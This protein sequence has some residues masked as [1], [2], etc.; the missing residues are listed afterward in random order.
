[1]GNME[2][3]LDWRGD[4]TFDVDP[5]NIVDAVILCQLIYTDFEGFV[6]PMG[7]GESVSIEEVCERYFNAYTDEEIISRK[8]YTR[9]SPFLMRRMVKSKRYAGLRLSNYVDEVDLDSDIQLSAV[10]YHLSDG[11]LFIG[12]RGTDSTLAG[13]KEDLMLSYQ[14]GTNGQLASAIYLNYI[15]KM[16]P[17][18]PI[19][20]V[21]GHSKGGNFAV[22]AAC[23]CNEEAGARIRKVYNLDGPGFSKEFVERPEYTRLIPKTE[24]VSPEVALVGCLFES[25]LKTYYVESTEKFL[26]QHDMFSWQVLA[27]HMVVTE[28]RAPISYKVEYMVDEWLLTLDEDTKASVIDTAFDILSEAE[29]DTFPE[30]TDDLF[31]NVGKIWSAAMNLPKDKQKEGLSTI[32]KMLKAG[33]SAILSKNEDIVPDNSTKL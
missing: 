21:G 33:G 4:I 23:C 22:Y 20:R 31:G 32:V 2:S 30:L 5:F 12:Y 26:L 18:V 6:P 15:R 17:D 25:K 28:N 24:S 16:F 11:S 14:V 13:W 3:Y 1:M 29:S 7:S 27:N 10:T 19:L 8:I 9:M